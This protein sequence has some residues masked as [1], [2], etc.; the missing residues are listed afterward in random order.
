MVQLDAPGDGAVVLDVSNVSPPIPPDVEAQ[1]FS[2][3]RPTLA[4]PAR[5]SRSRTGLGVGLH[6][7]QAIAL[8]HG[9]SIE[10]NHA[11]PFVVFSVRL[12]IVV[13]SG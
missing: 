8:A 5:L 4:D 11:D 3:F 6:I 9:G 1:L 7:A 12:P 13:V 2:A 10:Y